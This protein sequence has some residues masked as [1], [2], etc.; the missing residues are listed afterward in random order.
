M[1]LSDTTIRKYLAE[2]KIVILPTLE[3]KDI[4][5]I[6]VRL[7]LGEGILIPVPGQTVDL[8]EVSD[9][10]YDEQ[11]ISSEGYRLKSGDFILGTTLERFQVPT[12]IVGMLDGRSTYARLGLSIHCTSQMADGNFHEPGSTVL[13][14]KNNGL[15][16]IILRVGI[17]IAMLSFFELSEPVTQTDSF[18]YKGQVSVLAPDLKE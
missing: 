2:N 4:R 1:I 8:G 7:H 13:E 6:G 17:P 3:E 14:I 5:P 9:I 16:E 10:R 12:D 15:F 11:K 18:K